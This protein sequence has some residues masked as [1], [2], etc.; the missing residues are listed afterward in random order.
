MVKFPFI[1]RQEKFFGL[2]EESARNMVEAAQKLKKM[3]DSWE[4]VEGTVSEIAELEH[5]GDTITHQ[6]IAQLHR[7][8][9][10]P[11]DREDI[12]LL[13]QTLDDVPFDLRHLR[14]ILYDTIEPEWASKLKSQITNSIYS[15]LDGKLDKSPYKVF[16][17]FE[18]SK[19]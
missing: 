9:V 4:Y 17:D 3:V 19:K 2:F 16:E 5:Q 11:F 13:A 8:F 18:E 10:T 6:I 7:T 15:I 12:A 1:P 14:C